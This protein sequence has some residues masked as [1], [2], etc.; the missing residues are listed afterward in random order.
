VG[1]VSGRS[2]A[3][4]PRAAERRRI[5]L[6]STL[7]Q[8]VW[9]YET[10]QGLGFG[11]ALL[12][13]LERL[14]PDPAARARRLHAHLELFNSN[15]Y[16]ATL[17]MG[18]AVRVEEE[19]AREAAGARRGTPEVARDRGA[20]AEQRLTRLLR[21]LRGT[22]G[23]LGDDLFWAGWRPALGLTAA[24]VALLAPSPWPAIA[25]L[26]GYNAV[27]Q[28]VRWRGVRAGFAS[29]V[30]I[31]RVL[32]S[33]F[34][35]RIGTAARTLGAT[36]TGAA[37]GAGLVVSWSDGGVRGSGIFFILVV[38][39]WLAGLRAGSRGRSLS[40]ALALLAL[41]ILLSALFHLR[42]GVVSW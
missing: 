5:A 8:A 32:Q 29:G 41:V 9:N 16:L 33:S 20:G 12:P 38:F 35:Q 1:F 37:F 21:A 27:A 3:G 39:L 2:G 11:W 24:V 40:P 30:G 19:I 22:L 4:H 15:P 25:F 31:A 6:R 18:V 36:A 42:P 17:G 7:L 14:Y 26:V 28:T 10:L 13:A 34:W 23:A